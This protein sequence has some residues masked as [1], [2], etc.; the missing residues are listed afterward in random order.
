MSGPWPD[1]LARWL[2]AW[3]GVD[4]RLVVAGAVAAY[5]A[6]VAAGRTLW[7]VDLWPALGVPSGPSLFF[8]ARNV[9]AALECRRA[10]L[11]PL[12]DNP[13]DPWGRTMFYPRVW[14]LLRFV[15]LDQSD[16]DGFA[17]ALC[18][19]M[20]VVFC[21]L[22]GRVPGGTG[23]V[24]ALAACSPAVMFAVE[25]TNMDVALF[26]VLGLAALVWRRGE[27]ADG[28]VA[29]A[30]VL[31]AAVGKLYPVF[32]LVA[33]P[34]TRSRRAAL[35]AAAAAAAFGVY[36]VATL[37]D[38]LLVSRTATQGQHYSFGARILLA[39]AYQ[40]VAGEPFGGA[41]LAAQAVVL[42]AVAAVAGGL[43]L[44]AR[45]RHPPTPPATTDG[46]LLAFLLGTA[47]FVGTFAIG[48]SFDYRLV[49][50]L[51]TL[52]QLT[53]WVR[54][55]GGQRPAAAAAL[56]S[57]VAL[58]WVGPLSQPLRLADEFVTWAT[59]ALLL[60]LAAR[61]VPPLPAVLADLRG[62]G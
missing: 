17:V 14:L 53:R 32:G 27:G 11:D 55:G 12:R 39:R 31:A 8:D 38:V 52:P 1:R 59:V 25:R 18:L 22:A 16:T 19:A 21:L 49:V 54:D 13:C 15:G 29:P 20:L 56:L 33:F 42:L 36:V 10:G 57:T 34:A 24:L 43:W 3:P 2:A 23:V 60:R 51:L 37:D 41:A 61:V 62:R 4:G 58:L 47:V 50:L 40:A 7:G 44:V 45:R 28:V 48:N 30:L 26:S 35:A 5:L 46:P 6:A 9:T